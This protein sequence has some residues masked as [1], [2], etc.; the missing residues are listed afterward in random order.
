MRIDTIEDLSEILD[1]ATHD[2]VFEH[3]GESCPECGEHHK[4]YESLPDRPLTNADYQT[5]SEGGLLVKPVYRVHLE[6]VEF[7]GGYIKVAPAIFIV[8]SDDVLHYIEYRYGSGW[9]RAERHEIEF[10]PKASE[11]DIMERIYEKSDEIQ[12][13]IINRVSNLEGIPTIDNDPRP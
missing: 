7:P 11:E 3:S 4:Q 6:G 9:V 2:C 12:D 10:D 8:S 5:I 13:R 1:E